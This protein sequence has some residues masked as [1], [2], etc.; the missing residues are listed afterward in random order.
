MDWKGESMSKRNS[1]NIT[2][3][4]KPKKRRK[5]NPIKIII[6]IMVLGALIFG[7]TKLSKGIYSF[8]SNLGGKAPISNEET[9]SDK[10]FDL[11]DEKGTLKKKYTILVDPGHGGHDI[12][13]ESSRNIENGKNNVYEKDVALEIAKKV[14]SKLSKQ[15]DIEVIIS[16]TDDT[17]VSL[18]DRM[19]LANSRNV[20]LSVSVHLNAESGG[21]TAAGVETYYRRGATDGSKEL[22]EIVQSSIISH[23]EARDR[24]ARAENY[25]MVK[26]VTMPAILIETGF[27]TNPEEEK[28]L[29]S[30]KYQDQLAEG[31]VQGILSYLD[32]IAKQNK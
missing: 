32:N 27:L 20:D 28:K 23:V 9:N 30:N 11:E 7:V 26:G 19:E 17:F 3:I 5:L 1:R 25:D 22:A 12:G 29:T 21:N 16:R 8:L 6:L 10:Q 13:T 2:Y 15:N 18:L 24:G 14:A 31:I 4:N